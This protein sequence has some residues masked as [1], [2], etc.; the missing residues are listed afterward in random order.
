ME[1]IMLALHEDHKALSIW[2]VLEDPALWLPASWFQALPILSL[3][4]ILFHLRLLIFISNG[5]FKSVYNG[6]FKFSNLAVNDYLFSTSHWFCF[7]LFLHYIIFYMP[8]D[9]KI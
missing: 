1:E 6:E 2:R 8:L 4:L 5:D 7:V 3:V 9:S